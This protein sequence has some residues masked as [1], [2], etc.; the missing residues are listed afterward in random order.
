MPQPE[1]S[2]IFDKVEVVI[3]GQAVL[4]PLSLRLTERRIGLI[5]A[6]GSGKSSFIR[7]ING[8]LPPSAGHISVDGLALPRD[9]AAVRRKVGFVFQ[10]PDMQIIQ[11]TVAEDIA[12]GLHNLRRPKAEIAARVGAIMAEYG[13]TPFADSP[14]RIL[15]GGQ[16]QLLALCGVLIMQPEIIVLD[17]PTTQLDLR[18]KN[19]MANLLRT[20]PQRLI[21]VTHDMALL[22]GFDRVLVMDKGQI[23]YDGTPP[24]SIVFY[25][26]LIKARP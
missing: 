5:G 12:F 16:K 1:K 20:L 14:A 3:D 4:R 17:E 25:E 6:N 21:I 18:H 26:E 10:N 19:R 13:L 11:P 22:A 23:I 15:S 7:L 8:L 2:I 9:K 24:Q